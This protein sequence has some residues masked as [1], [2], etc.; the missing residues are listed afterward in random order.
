[1]AP[2]ITDL[3]AGWSERKIVFAVDPLDQPAE[4]VNEMVDQDASKRSRLLTQVTSAAQKEGAVGYGYFGYGFGN[5][6]RNQGRYDL[7][8]SRYPDQEILNKRWSEYSQQAGARTDPGLG[9][10][11][12]WLPR[13][14]NDHDFRLMVRS[15]LFL[16]RLECTAAQKEEQLVHLARIAAR[17]VVEITKPPGASKPIPRT[18]P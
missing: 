3:G 9:E 14:G 8:L 5:L 12:I 1:V 13:T 2:R 15:G 11:A 18:K 6:V 17:S 10:A 7:Y 16:M 4:T